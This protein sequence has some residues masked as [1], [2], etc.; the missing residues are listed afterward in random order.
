[1]IDHKS[2]YQKRHGAFRN[3]AASS[4]LIVSE[5]GTISR[6]TVTVAKST[7][8][9][10]G[11][12]LIQ[13]AANGVWSQP[14]TEAPPASQAPATPSQNRTALAKARRIANGQQETYHDKGVGILAERVDASSGEAEGSI[15]TRLAE[16]SGDA[17]V[18][19]D[20]ITEPEKAAIL[21]RL[22]D[23]FVVTR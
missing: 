16:V 23:S 14:G 8:L 21:A 9:T 1:M 6:D 7:N 13:S 11:T 12:V 22:A 19:P 18:W 4:G 15:I 17:L 20:G 3:E 5:V 10:A 2:V